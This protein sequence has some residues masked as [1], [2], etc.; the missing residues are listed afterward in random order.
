MIGKI[1][2]TVV[3]RLQPG[4]LIW[5]SQTVGFG[6]RLQLRH[7]HYLCRYRLD[8]RQRFITIGRH[9]APWTPE[10]AR[11]EAQRLLGIVATGA[12]PAAAEVEGDTFIIVADR[13][14]ARQAGRLRLKSLTEV[15]RH[16]RKYSA[17]LHTMALT[18]ITRRDVAEV[19]SSVEAGSGA[20]SRNRVRSSLSAMWRWAIQEGL[21]E[22]NVVAGTGT[23]DEGGSRDRVLS[24]AE[25]RKLWSALDD[26]DFSKSIQLLLLTGCRRQEIA[27]LRW[28]EVNL[29][30][31]TITL[32][33]ERVKNG[34]EFVLPLSRQAVAILQ[35]CNGTDGFVFKGCH[36]TIWKKR[37]EARAGIAPWV[38]HD[39][40]RSM[41]THCAELGVMPHVIENLLNHTSGH[42]AGVAG[43][44]NRSR[45]IAPMREAAQLFADWIDKIT[46]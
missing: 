1:T 11:K 32:P 38:I 34:R 43:V 21:T 3:D 14:L 23:A 16:L 15:E 27:R 8:G 2:K 13:Y 41:A 7:V 6:A 19:L 17:P 36:A 46:T 37:L 30:D 31:A 5:D 20:S 35:T 24:E 40:R 39:L 12:D 42:K 33:A 22:V 29:A 44:Y 25:I 18:E 28:S 4:S 9:G 45:L 26:T 10:T